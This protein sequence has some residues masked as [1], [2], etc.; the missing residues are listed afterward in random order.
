MTR[1][2]A[3]NEILNHIKDHIQLVMI[4][5]ETDPVYRLGVVKRGPLNGEPEPDVARLYATL[6]SNDPDEPKEW[7]D[8]VI[9]QEIPCSQIWRRCYTCL[10]G[11]LLEPTQE[12]LEA[13]SD[14]ASYIK[15][16]L[17]WSISTTK[18][19]GLTMSDGEQV[20]RG[21]TDLGETSWMEQL[22]GPPDSYQFQGKIRFNILTRK[23]CQ[24]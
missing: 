5:Q 24:P 19:S 13:A 22:G 9:E 1:L 10:W 3:T 8:E 21:C 7:R 14:I 4:D 11:A 15:A 2:T 23:D 16:K 12:S 18:L 6:F 17:E 20:I